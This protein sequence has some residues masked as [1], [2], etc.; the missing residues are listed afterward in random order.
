MFRR[1]LLD[2]F[3]DWLEKNREA[4]GKWYEK[5]QGETWRECATPVEIMGTAMWMFNRVADLGVLAGIGPDQ[6]SIHE[7]REGLD[8][9][10]TVR[11]LHLIKACM[12]LQCLPRE[13]A[14]QPIAI[15]SAKQ[16]SLK[17]WIQQ[18]HE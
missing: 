6:V 9:P 18:T 13:I 5:L 10:S 12:N 17:L 7:I 14:N 8:K 3:S 15:I 4:I 11:L 16:F 2:A 1:S